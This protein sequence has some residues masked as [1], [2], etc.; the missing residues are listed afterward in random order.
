MIKSIKTGD[1]FRVNTIAELMKA[2]FN[3]NLPYR[4]SY[5]SP[6]KLQKYIPGGFYVWVDKFTTEGYIHN[7]GYG[8]EWKNTIDDTGNKIDRI[9]IGNLGCLTDDKMD[10][11][12]K[13][14]LVFMDKR[15]KQK[16]L[17]FLGVFGETGIQ[18]HHNIFKGISYKKIKD[19]ITYELPDPKPSAEE[20]QKT[21][22]QLKIER[23]AAISAVSMFQNIPGFD[24]ICGRSKK[25]LAD[26]EKEIE[27]R[28]GKDALK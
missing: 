18:Y 23:N 27:D 26:I 7:M 16:I 11:H 14:I 5:F 12:G 2:L 10:M 6:T 9:F 15:P 3:T 17:E 24:D 13:K 28:F 1:L 22:R 20:T 4:V 19:E 21:L 8:I 25:I